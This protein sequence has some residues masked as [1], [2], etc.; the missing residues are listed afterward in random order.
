MH[1]RQTFRRRPGHQSK[2]GAGFFL[3]AQILRFL[4]DWRPPGPCSYLV[5]CPGGC[6]ATFCISV[7][8]RADLIKLRSTSCNRIDTPKP[9]S[10]F[11]RSIFPVPL[12]NYLA[13]I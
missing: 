1:G 11:K 12:D 4:V 2:N 5:L 7:A 8:F 10:S 9:G 3:P 13:A 6:K